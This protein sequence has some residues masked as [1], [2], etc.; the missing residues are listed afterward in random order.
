MKTVNI[1]TALAQ[2]RIL[3]AT[4]RAAHQDAIKSDTAT[5]EALVFDLITPSVELETALLR[6]SAAVNLDAGKEAKR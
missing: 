4:I 3:C 5:A 1:N 2:A 6:V